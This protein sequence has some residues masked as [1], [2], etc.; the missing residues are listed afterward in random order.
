MKALRIITFTLIVFIA[1]CSQLPAAQPTPTL[2]STDTPQ[3]TNTVTPTETPTATPEP[4]LTLVDMFQ[5]PGDYIHGVDVDGEERWFTI[6][7]PTGYHLGDQVPLV[8]NFHGRTSDVFE[9]E[10]ISSM[11]AKANEEGFVVVNPQALDNPPTWWGAI[12]TEVGDADF[13]FIEALL[14]ELRRYIR[15]DPARI[16]AT[17]L[18][19]GGSMVTRLGCDMSNQIAAVAPV[20]GGH[21]YREQC[22]PVRPVPMIV[23]HG[24]EDSI[25]PYEG[26]EAQ[27]EDDRALPS[28]KEWVT[29]WAFRNGC[30]LLPVETMISETVRQETWTNCG[31]GADVVL[32]SLLEGGHYWPQSV[33]DE[34]DA[35]DLI[36][37]FFE[38]HPIPTL[39]SSVVGMP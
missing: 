6:H 9:Q 39:E 27:S 3:P 17:G 2:R 21:I 11:H 32:Y 18:S 36:W 22:D 16:Y 25:I 24:V 35:T 8:L 33:T 5:D 7:I 31:E 19:N 26:I 20:S 28:V 13:V 38:A 10:K 29:D 12:P 14:D 34:N 15:I 30:G 1:G 23:F 37:E 4:T